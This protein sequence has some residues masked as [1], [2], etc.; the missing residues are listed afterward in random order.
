VLPMDV[1]FAPTGVSPLLSHAEFLHTTCPVCGE[2]ARRETDTMDTFVDSS[3][4]FLRYCSPNYEDG[5]W[6]PAKAAE[7]MPID[8]YGGGAEHAVM[9]LLYFRFFTKALRDLGM[10]KV[11]EPTLKLRN[12]GQVLGADHNRMSKSRG[13][14][15]APD[16]LVDRYGADT[17][18]AFLMFIGPWDQGGPWNPTGIEGVYRWLG[19]VWNASQPASGPAP[20][21]AEGRELLRALRRLAH[22]TIGEVTD[23]YEGM[24]FNTAIA[25][26]MEL[27]NALVREREAGMGGT[28]AYAEA[29]DIL[30]RLLAPVAPHVAE[31]LWQRRGKPY[32]I[33]TQPWPEADPTLTAAETIELPVQVD[34]K[35][36]DRLVVTPDT[37]AAEIE[38]MA[39]DSEHVQRYL[40]GRAPLR[41]IQVPGKLV[42]V[43]TPR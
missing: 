27:T 2:P 25:H 1:D 5:P 6:D 9:H 32:S 15:Q 39:L 38:R 18:R 8:L 33:H 31:E 23:D 19:R 42:N 30:L 36:R 40:A 26:L 37:S 29:V 10:L 41:V 11:D 20:A 24:R 16:E 13:N 28:D 43:V 14:V 3:W 21:D 12:Q 22:V 34:G 17:V 7:W 4:Y 35:L